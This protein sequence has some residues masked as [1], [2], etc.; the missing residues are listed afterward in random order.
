M[1]SLINSVN[2]KT[3]RCI[4]PFQNSNFSMKTLPISFWVSIG[5]RKFRWFVLICLF[6]KNIYQVC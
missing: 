1:T 4:F 5:L 6:F 3:S 2:V